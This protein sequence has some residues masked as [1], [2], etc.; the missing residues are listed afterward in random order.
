MFERI[1]VIA[2][3]DKQACIEA[4]KT[5]ID[6]INNNSKKALIHKDTAEALSMPVDDG[7]ETADCLLVIGGDGTILRSAKI[8]FELDIPIIGVNFGRVGFLSE[9]EPKDL[10]PA[11]EQLLGGE[12]KEEA[13][14]LLD[15]ELDGKHYIGLNDALLCKHHH[16]RTIEVDVLVDGKRAMSCVCDGMLVSTPTGSTAYALS[17]GG[18]I[19][20]TDLDSLQV[21]PVCPHTTSARP[22]MLS[23]NALITIRLLDDRYN[24]AE[25]CVDG[26][27][28][29]SKLRK[30]QTL[31]VRSAQKRLRF[32][33]LGDSNYFD[34]VRKKLFG[35]S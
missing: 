26:S 2:H 24:N 30:D 28:I 5:A 35:V 27:L 16:S 20:D 17:A 11:L 1:G 14:M 22:I 29:L 8:A 12:C 33:R 3:A 32:L 18:P 9:I 25:L 6:F 31:F 23:P 34:I 4:M 21:T 10:L 7:F 13:R 15:A 19:V